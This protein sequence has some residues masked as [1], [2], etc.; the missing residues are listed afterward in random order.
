MK[1]IEQRSAILRL[2]LLVCIVRIDRKLHPN[3]GTFISYMEWR[4]CL[5]RA[6]QLNFYSR[7]ISLDHPLKCTNMHMHVLKY[8]YTRQAHGMNSIIDLNN[9][10]RG[11]DHKP[12]S[13]FTTVCNNAPFAEVFGFASEYEL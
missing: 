4:L 9:L 5:L 7:L 10:A 2:V 3:L 13:F 11:D 6:S 1:D 8:K 12:C